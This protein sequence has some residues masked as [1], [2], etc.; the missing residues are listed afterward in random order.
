MVARLVVLVT[1]IITKINS[2]FLM[3]SQLTLLGHP[4]TI[5]SMILLHNRL[6]SIRI[7]LSGILISADF[8]GRRLALERL[9]YLRLAEWFVVVDLLDHLVLW[10]LK[11]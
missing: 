6:N 11:E 10:H 8:A 5:A 4:S 7:V 2:H 1:V 9:A 3:L